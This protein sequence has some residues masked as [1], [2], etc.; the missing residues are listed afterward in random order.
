[1]DIQNR[2]I[3]AKEALKISNKSDANFL[4]LVHKLYNAH[5]SYSMFYSSD[6]QASITK[7]RVF[8]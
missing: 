3:G 6:F 5:K 4:D 2:V 7:R 8:S 1:M